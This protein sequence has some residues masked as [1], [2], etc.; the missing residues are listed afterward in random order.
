MGG[1][2]ERMVQAVKKVLKE[3]M[4]TRNP[5]DELL[6]SM[7]LEVER[8]INCHPLT[9]IPLEKQSDEALTPNH[10]LLGTS[11]GHKPDTVRT[12]D[13]VLLRKN[14]MKS[15]QYANRFWKRWLR[16][17]L[18]TLTRRGKWWGPVKPIEVGDVVI[19]V[20]ESNPRNV[21]PKGRVLDRILSSD[22]QV[23]T[24]TVQ[25]SSGI[26]VRPAVKLSVLD[27]QGGNPTSIV[28]PGGTVVDNGIK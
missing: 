25:T 19:V 16:E 28:I 10:F 8:T 13:G 5:S 1:T 24:V 6:H 27:V 9:Y 21:W 17:Y 4:P 12:D 20:D 18:P 3:I 11:D 26:Y 7:L 23:R 2:W 15:Q 14:W 22:G